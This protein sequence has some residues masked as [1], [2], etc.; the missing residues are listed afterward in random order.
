[1]I[2]ALAAQVGL[3]G[4]LSAALGVGYSFERLMVDQLWAD[5]QVYPGVLEHFGGQFLAAQ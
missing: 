2:V 5:L 1:M 4:E 3:A